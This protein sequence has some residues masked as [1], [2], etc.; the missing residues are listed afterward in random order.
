MSKSKLALHV[1]RGGADIDAAV[2]L[3]PWCAVKA[4]NDSAP[5]ATAAAQGIPVRILRL[6]NIETMAPNDAVNR[7]LQQNLSNVT[8]IQLVCEA[9]QGYDPVWQQQVI[10]GLKPHFGGTFLIGGFPTG[11][12]TDYTGSSIANYHFPQYE[13]LYPLLRRSDT[14]LAL[15]EYGS[16]LPGTV[17]AQTWWPWTATRH[18]YV[19]ADLARQGINTRVIITESGRDSVNPNNNE[20][21]PGG[22]KHYWGASQYLSYLQ[23]LDASDL[24]DDGVICR[25]IFTLGNNDQW[26]SFDISGIVSQIAAYVTTQKGHARVPATLFQFDQGPGTYDCWVRCIESFFLR[27]GYSHDVDQIFQAAKGYARPV[28]GETATFTQVKQAITTLAAQDGVKL[29][30]IDLDNPGQ[31]SAALDD[32]DTANPWTVIAGVAEQVLQPGQQYGHYIILERRSGDTVTVVDSNQHEDG[33]VS[34]T[35]TWEQV[36]NAMAANWDPVVDAI[37]AKLIGG[38]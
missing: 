22:W 25:C 33:N 38:A 32:P 36:V 11:N 37:G 2:R 1:H 30:L 12:P 23:A 26:L 10:D 20:M 17:D 29:Q 27:Y 8:H 4:F 6:Y 21:P 13:P 24:Q 15:D 31:V 18:K 16:V 14:A 35:Y 5:L 28:N 3:A 19:L 34:G 9:S 7:W